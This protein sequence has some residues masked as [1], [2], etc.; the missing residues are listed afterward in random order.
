M[1]IAIL[2]G[3]LMGTASAFFLLTHPK[4]PRSLKVTLIDRGA[5]GAAATVAS[6]GNVR[7]QGR[8]FR[9]M[10]LAHHS[11]ALWI[12][13]ETL[14]G[15][16]IEFRATGHVRAVFHQEALKDM[17]NFASAALQHGLEI[18]LLDQIEMQRRFPFLSK[19]AIAGSFSPQDGS[20][21]PRLVAPAFAR[22]AVRH[23]LVLHDHTQVV[24][25]RPTPSGFRIEVPDE[26]IEADLLLNTAG[27]WGGQVAGWLGESAPLTAYAPQMGVTE[28]LEHRILPV[29]GVWARKAEEV[30]Y[31]R[32]VERGN[33]VFGG[34]PREDLTLVPGHAKVNPHRTL[35]QLEVLTHLIPA[36][37]HTTVIRTWSGC[38]GYVDDMLPV[39]GPSSRH[40]G[41]FHAFGFCGHGFQLGP[42]VGAEMAELMLTGT[43]LT[44]TNP[45]HIGRFQ[46]SATGD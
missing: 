37:R 41:L 1:H 40:D 28:P 34:G 21:N 16:D 32:Q 24:S 3:G 5:I 26:V 31:C 11:L 12:R 36:L 4:A 23:G 42:G 22:A 35:R 45:F 15:S 19:D 46:N 33:I 6:F 8:D 29:V 17:Q 13:L 7:R 10:A 27:A 14:L 30:I 43:S 25:V 20:G 44:D 39:I 2:G 38:E 9:Q 18:E